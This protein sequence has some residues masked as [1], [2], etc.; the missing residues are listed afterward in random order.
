VSAW[1]IARLSIMGFT[2]FLGGFGL[3]I[4]SS[5]LYMGLERWDWVLALAWVALTLWAAWRGLFEA[6]LFLWGGW[7][8]ALGV[9]SSESEEVAV[10]GRLLDTLYLPLLALPPLVY[11]FSPRRGQ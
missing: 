2:L 9:L 11:L 4:L 6:T 8:M 5:L 3:S 7:L 1:R 10:L